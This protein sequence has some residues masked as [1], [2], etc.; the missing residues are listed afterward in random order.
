[1]PGPRGTYPAFPGGGTGSPLVLTEGLCGEGV[2]DGDGDEE[3][4]RDLGSKQTREEG[5]SRCPGH[6]WPMSGMLPVFTESHCK[7]LSA[8]DLKWLLSVPG[9]LLKQH[10][11]KETPGWGPSRRHTAPPARGHQ[12]REPG[13]EVQGG[14]CSLQRTRR[15][16]VRCQQ[17]GQGR[18]AGQAADSGP[19]PSTPR[20]PRLP[21]LPIPPD[22]EATG[23]RPRL[24]PN[25]RSN[26]SH[27]V[28]PPQLPQRG[29]AATAWD[30]RPALPSSRPRGWGHGTEV[31]ARP[32]APHHRPLRSM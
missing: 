6:V 4:D 18:G 8:S 31:L 17:Q 20:P 24:Q 25:R 29:S 23:S 11:E 27:T 7:S 22:W 1:M 16:S 2:G 32:P 3:K 21:G 26:S 12:A 10:Q 5:A 19:G 30:R 9:P 15:D 28:R 14:G 13:T